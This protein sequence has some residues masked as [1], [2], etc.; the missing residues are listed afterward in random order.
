MISEFILFTFPYPPSVIGFSFSCHVVAAVSMR[1]LREKKFTIW[2][3]LQ[4]NHS[5]VIAELQYGE[6][7][8]HEN[9]T[10]YLV[11]KGLRSNECATLPIEIAIFVVVNA[12]IFNYEFELL[13]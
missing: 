12:G 6:K 10:F 7:P 4:K 3:L 13:L 1:S 9:E 8:H 2:H 11:V 5:V